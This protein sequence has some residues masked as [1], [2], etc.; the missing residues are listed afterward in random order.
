MKM[1]LQDALFNWLQIQ[2][3]W[4][5]RPSDR[6]AQDTVLF[7]EKILQEDY[8]VMNIKKEV[9]QK[10]FVLRFLQGEEEKTVSFLREFAEKLLRD[11]LSEPKYGLP[12]K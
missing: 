9:D 8:Q 6:S 2:I 7:F 10:H 12:L 5:A 11:L 3:V 4:E 1:E